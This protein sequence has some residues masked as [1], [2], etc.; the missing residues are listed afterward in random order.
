MRD[1]EHWWGLQ[2]CLQVLE[3][4][5]LFKRRCREVPPIFVPCQ[6]I[7]WACA[8]REVLDISSVDA[9][10]AKEALHLCLVLGDVRSAEGLGVLV[11][12]LELTRGHHVAEVLHPSLDEGALHEVEGDSGLALPRK[13]CVQV[14][15]VVLHCRGE[16]DDL[17]EVDEEHLPLG[18]REDNVECA[19]AGCRGVRY[20]EQYDDLLEQTVVAGEGR[21][22]SFVSP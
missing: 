5:R 2:Y 14:F 18:P 8:L 7:E 3:G 4:S 9:S 15:A 12:Q 6:I 13:D 22:L 1:G 11:V 20:P 10:C 17:V 19:F 16:D 21:L